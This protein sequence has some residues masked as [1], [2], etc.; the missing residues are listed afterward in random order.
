MADKNGNDPRKVKLST[1]KVVTLDIST[2]TWGE[3]MAATRPGAPRAGEAFTNL[4]TKV[5]G[6]TAEEF[7][8]LLYVDGDKV[9]TGIFALLR[10]PV[11]ADPN[12]VE[13]ST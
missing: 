1:G 2:V 3:V 9:E 8:A 5:S 11:G 7:S 10:N 6:M 13:P 12:S 4:L